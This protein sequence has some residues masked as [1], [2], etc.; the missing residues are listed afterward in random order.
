M[1]D[2]DWLGLPD[3]ASR[4]LG[5]GV[6]AANDEFFAD[7]E[8]LIR[9]EEPVF[10]PHTFTAKGQEYDGWETRRRRGHPGEHDWAIVRLGV[11]G[12]VRGVVVD[13]AFFKG[14]YPPFVSID[15]CA[16]DGYPAPGELGGWVAIVP[17]SRVAGDTANLFEVDDPKRYTHVRLNIHPDGGVARLRVHGHPLA[18]PGWLDDVPFDLAA[19]ANGAEVVLA[20][21]GFFSPPVNM[22]RPGQSRFMSD[23]WETAR[24]RDGGHDWAVVRLA[25][26][27]VLAVSDVDTSHYR[28]NSPESAV[29]EGTNTD[30]FADL[31]AADAWWP[32]APVVRLQP[33]TAHR[34][35]LSSDRAVTHVRLNIHPDGGIGRFRVYGRLTERGRADIE[36]RW[37][38]T[39]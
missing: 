18:D 17:R 14:N 20:S 22:L 37:H 2:P 34:V 13:T 8:N 7:R 3:L 19:L 5:G 38:E 25:A 27:A 10:R 36:R 39:S 11:H 6:I 24:R 16:A 31:S 21:D 23:G 32:L 29:I 28:G 9:P 30:D 26:E 1:S 12:V 15:A 33:D 35:R 4:L